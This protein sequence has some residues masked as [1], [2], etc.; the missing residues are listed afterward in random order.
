MIKKMWQVVYKDYGRIDDEF[1]YNKECSRKVYETTEEAWKDVIADCT[2]D[3]DIV[4]IMNNVSA[5]IV[6]LREVDVMLSGEDLED[7]CDIMWEIKVHG[8]GLDVPEVI[9]KTKHDALVWASNMYK[10]RAT[11][12]L[13]SDSITIEPLIIFNE[14]EIETQDD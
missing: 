2:N 7:D 9:F 1:L 12:Y 13:D 11:D 6:S 14:K 10:E 4:Y 3:D 8:Y 5:G